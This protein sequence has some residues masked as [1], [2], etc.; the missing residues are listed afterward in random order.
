MTTFTCSLPS[1]VGFTSEFL[2][3]EPCCLSVNNLAIW[4]IC[5][6]RFLSGSLD[7]VVEWIGFIV[8]EPDF[9]MWPLSHS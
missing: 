5:T 2:G 3:N 1:H 7:S 6:S 4:P 8:V 9:G